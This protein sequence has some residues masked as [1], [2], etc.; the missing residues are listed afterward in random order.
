MGRPT[1]AGMRAF[2][3]CTAWL[4]DFAQAAPAA[5]LVARGRP[6]IVCASPDALLCTLSLAWRRTFSLPSP[7]RLLQHHFLAC[8]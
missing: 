7:A 4:E 3:H 2:L 8:L 5:F 1:T 6:A